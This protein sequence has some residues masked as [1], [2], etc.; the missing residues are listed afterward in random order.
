MD[1]NTSY[2]GAAG[3][4]YS[5]SMTGATT[6]NLTNA[7][8]SGIPKFILIT[9]TTDANVGNRNLFLNFTPY[10]FSP[11]Y[12]I[13]TGINQPA[14]TVYAYYFA[15]GETTRVVGTSHYYPLPDNFWWGI[16]KTGNNQISVGLTGGFAGDS[17]F[18]VVYGL[19][20]NGDAS[21]N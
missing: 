16:G 21:N 17:R 14:S 8:V 15:P 9:V 7:N 1:L 10:S 20:H 2:P 13:D 18:I 11:A 3:F 19:K 5:S 6:Y 4:R 12:H